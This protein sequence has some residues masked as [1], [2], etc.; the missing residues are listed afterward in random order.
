M[1][2]AMVKEVAWREIRTRARTKSFKWITG[3]LVGVAIAGP[4]IATLV[5]DNVTEELREVTIGLA[6]VD[7]ALEDQI[8]AFA[9]G[10]LDVTFVDLTGL[11]SAQLEQALS[12]DDVNLVLEPGPTLVW[13]RFTDYEI[14]AV[15][16]TVLQ[17][18]ELLVKGRALGLD[19]GDVVELLTPVALEERF[20]N[21][22]D[23]SEGVTIFVSFLGLMAAFMLPQI[24]GQLTLMSVVEEKSTRVIEV[25]LNHLRPRTLLMG[26]V[27][28]VGAL[29]VLQLVVVVGGLTVA[30]LLTDFVEIPASV[31]RFVPIIL[32]SILGGLAIYNT[33]FAL[34]GSLIS[35]QEDASQVMMPIF[36]PLMAGFFVGQVAITGNAESVIVRIL[37]LF[38][39][40]AP[41]LLPLRV[42]RDAIAPWEVALSLALLAFGV[43]LLVRIAGRVYEFTLLHTGS[44]VGW[45]ELVR[46]SRGATL[47]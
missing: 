32:V 37:T 35:R 12:D 22:A 26:K 21:E 40:T 9:E 8:L 1:S 11:S 10:G 3:I 17:Q 36:I 44:R 42:A 30:L 28:G 2:A 14:A 4:V 47:D 25:L 5:P 41:M 46:L 43:W 13:N 39:L 45:G 38:P 33:L 7:Q 27:L 16:Y 6:G 15:V 19:Q 20:A 29:A 18:Q 34:L 31:W 23:A 24:F